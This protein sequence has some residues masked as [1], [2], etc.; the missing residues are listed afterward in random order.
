MSAADFQALLAAL[1]GG[2]A[3]PAPAPGTVPTTTEDFIA[4]KCRVNFQSLLKFNLVGDSSQL[5]AVYGAIPKGIR[6]E[7]TT[8]LQVSYNDHSRKKEASLNAPFTFTKELTST[9]VNL[10]FYAGDL[11]CLDE[12]FPSFCTI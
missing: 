11:N 3:A 2:H 5:P 7:E 6:K 12:D 9:I 8:V 10:V 1:R 4:K